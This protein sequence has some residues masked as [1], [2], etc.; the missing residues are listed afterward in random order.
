MFLCYAQETGDVSVLTAASMKVT[1]FW[2]VAPCSLV[3]DYW[4]FR[5]SVCLHKL[6]ALAIT[7]VTR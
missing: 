5:D 4:R 7:W 6:I 3:A 1:V 2:I